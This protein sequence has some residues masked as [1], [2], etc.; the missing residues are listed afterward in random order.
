M[1][2]SRIHTTLLIAIFLGVAWK[3]SDI[4]NSSRNDQPSATRDRHSASAP[5]RHADAATLETTNTRQDDRRNY[6]GI[7]RS[8]RTELMEAERS[9]ILGRYRSTTIMSVSDLIRRSLHIPE[10]EETLTVARES[11]RIR[12]P[13]VRIRAP[14]DLEAAFISETISRNLGLAPFESEQQR[15]ESEEALRSEFLNYP[16]K[17]KDCHHVSSSN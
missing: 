2:N 1:T 15:A 8:I 5:A 16:K 7:I 14:N 17:T 4:G 6:H 13:N 3:L 10:G 11:V 9:R 12:A